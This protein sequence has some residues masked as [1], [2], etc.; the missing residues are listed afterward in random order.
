VV[1]PGGPN[2][3]VLRF[4]P[5]AIGVRETGQN[6]TA[7]I[8]AEVRD[9]KNNPV[10]DGTEVTFSIVHGPG[11]G[12]SL[13][14]SPADMPIPTVGGLARASIS[15]GTIS[16]NVRIEA[17]VTT[18]GGDIVAK[19]SEILIHAGPP[20]ME[21]R[22]VYASTHLTIAAEQL[23]IWRT[24]GTTNI[25][26]AVFDKY[27]NPVQEGTAVYLTTSGGGVST[28]TAYTD[29]QGKAQ[30]ILTGGNPQPLI[31]KYY[32]GELMQDPN[33][34]TVILPGPVEYNVPEAPGGVE[35]LL[36][37]FEGSLVA[38]SMADSFATSPRYHGNNAVME[39]DSL[40]NDGVARIIA[41]TEG[42]DLA[43]N[44]IRAWDQITVVYSGFVDYEDNT[45]TTLAGDTLHLGQAATFIFSLMDDNG[46][47]IE[48]NSTISASLTNEVDAKLTWTEIN[49]GNGW[50]KVYYSLTVINNVDPTKPNP[51][52]GPTN[53]K[54][55]WSNDH[56][57]GEAITASG[58][59]I[60]L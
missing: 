39:Y 43:G 2:S 19:A 20:Y 47:P 13:S 33:D 5:K 37:N 18:D 48:S 3:I 34:L 35:Y 7:I 23:N 29:A 22:E 15:S 41:Y 21:N 56:Q 26:I 57:F 50:G 30:V 31:Y 32:Y 38:N 59:V 51:K 49:T 42:H 46:N 44:T 17:S 16:G 27:H 8:E 12:E 53:I 1:V 6:Q 11:G 40:E 36:P 54:I 9:A 45:E 14:P 52:T 4:S 58:V 60:A 24:L 10:V 55:S 25:S 28:H